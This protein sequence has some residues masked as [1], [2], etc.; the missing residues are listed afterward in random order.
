MFIQGNAEQVRVVLDGLTPGV[1][2]KIRER[3]IRLYFLDAYGIVKERATNPELL[4]RMQGIVLLGVFLK[5]APFAASRKL[6]HDELMEGVEN[7]LRKYFGKRGEQVVKENLECVRRGYD[8]I[9]QVPAEWVK[10]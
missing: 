6:G 9:G 10:S 4:L 8:E 7:V 5:M 2:A 1:R 3:G